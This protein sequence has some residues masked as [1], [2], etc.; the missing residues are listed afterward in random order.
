MPIFSEVLQSAYQSKPDQVIITLQQAGFPDRPITYKD[1]LEGATSYAQTFARQG[2]Q[3]GEV[4][5]L[6]LQHGLD[7]VYA[8][9]GAVLHGAVPAIMPYLTEKL[10]PERY[11]HDLEALISVTQPTAIVTYPDFE[12]EV[13]P[14]LKSG[15][16]VR[17]LILSDSIEAPC[18]PDFT[19]FAGMQRDP[20][21]IVLLQH[22]SG[23]TGL[24]KGVALS[25]Q[26]VFH[27][28]ENLGSVLDL[29]MQDVVVS[30]LPLYHDMGLITGFIMPI[31]TGI[32]LVLLSPF[33]WV[34]AP[35]RL[36]Q[37]VSQYKGTLVWL[38]NFAYYFC[39][40]KIR[41]RHMAG[42][43][44][45]SWR[46]VINCS[47]PVRDDGHQIFLEKF[48]PYGFSEKALAVS[49][50]MA[51]NVFAVTQTKIDEPLYIEDI[52]REL[53]QTRKFALPTSDRNS[54][55]RM[56]SC[57]KPI[58]NVEV[59]IVDQN[60]NA[61]KDRRV[62]EIAVQS[63]CMLKE[64]YHRPDAT[65]ETVLTDGYFLTGDYG[66]KVGEE[67]FITGRK[68][69]L[70]I[71]GGKNVYPMDIEQLAMEVDGVHPGRVSVFGIYDEEK[72]TEDVILVAE[73]DTQEEVE[74]QC[75]GDQ[76]RAVVTRGSAIALRH[77]Y[78]VNPGWM[79]KTSSGK[80]SRYANR[81]K[82]SQEINRG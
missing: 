12:T 74:R 54:S 7:L 71:V 13:R 80:N 28:L 72:G 53:L 58:P 43:D 65:E 32:P 59:K 64:Y 2:I 41:D 76:I 6:I 66:Y 51:E 38:P 17:S 37:A 81:E 50:A 10:L 8:F 45:S 36:F 35:Q 52:N 34:K 55:V 16:S 78:L 1:L 40:Q 22:S 26:A 67:L 75:I 39:A 69:D 61:L 33:D 27:Q 68:K 29:S 79:V 23:T 42:V 46:A 25:H 62:G 15:D 4:V 24:Q 11:R 5:I 56:V 14:A 9:W 19:Q 31:L 3:P 30:W 48:G 47:E 73:V 49:Y 60:G 57:G 70:I 63:N 18:E 20:E 44:L 82:Y 21:D 77:V